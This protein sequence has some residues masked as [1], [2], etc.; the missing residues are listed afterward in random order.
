MP[1]PEDKSGA[2]ILGNLTPSGLVAVR[3][4]LCK[5]VT[6]NILPVKKEGHGCLKTVVAW[7]TSVVPTRSGG[8]CVGAAGKRPL[9][10]SEDTPSPPC[11]GP[12]WMRKYIVSEIR[13]VLKTRRRHFT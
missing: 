4:S 8:C 11:P 6:E 5:A 13:T 3:Y 12:L 2:A 10:Y 7:M 1:T 9:Y